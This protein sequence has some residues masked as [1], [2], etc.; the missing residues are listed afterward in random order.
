MAEPPQQS[1]PYFDAILAY[2]LRGPTRFHVP[3]HKAGSGADPALRHALGEALSLDIPQGI[4]GIDV[5]AS[6]TPY[7]QAELL[8]A[9][10]HGTQQ[11]WFLTN[12]ATQG[13]HA[14]ALAVAPLG[15]QVVAQR[16]SHA[17]V[18]DGL[19]LSGGIPAFVAPEVDARLGM[20]H[21]VAPE[22]LAERL[23]QTPDARAAFVVSPTYYGVCADVAA[24]AEVAHEAGVPLL[25]DQAW[26]PHFGFHPRVPETAL[27]LGADAVLTST[28]KIAGSLTQS[29]ML[30]VARASL[31]DVGTLDRAVRIVR[32]TSPSSLLLISLDASR[33]QLAVHGHRLLDRTLAATDRARAQLADVDGVTVLGDELLGQPGVHGIDPLRIVLDVQQTGSSGYAVAAALRETYDVNVELSTDAAVVL[34]VGMGED[35]SALDNIATEVESVIGRLVAGGNADRPAPTYDIAPGVTEL[36]VSPREAFLGEAETVPVAQAAGRISCESI[37]AYPPGIPGVL[38]GE[39]ITAELLDN[40]RRVVDE[41]ARLHGAADPALDT[42]RVLKHDPRTP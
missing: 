21:G 35:P 39:L 6:P 14:L 13:N 38:P 25:V 22:R 40:L 26:G 23:A 7:E 31:V 34:V 19:V 29:A 17:S 41:G 2:G 3:G 27:R 10:A 1:A 36:V 32:S 12:G 37:A 11:T 16:N 28:H 42:I 9:T 4:F 20:A 5:G 24:L 33:R 8:A 15:A 18:V 30:H